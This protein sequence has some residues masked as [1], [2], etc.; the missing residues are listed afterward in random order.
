MDRP[1][2]RTILN[3]GRDAHIHTNTEKYLTK[4]RLRRH[5]QGQDYGATNK[6]KTTAPQT[7]TRLRRHKQGQDYGATNKDKTTAPQTRTS[8]RR[9][10]LRQMPATW[11][12]SLRTN[13]NDP[14]AQ[15][16]GTSWCIGRPRLEREENAVIW[17]L[18]REDNAVISG[19]TGK[20]MP[21]SRG[22]T[23]KRMPSSRGLT[24]KNAVISGLDREENAVISGFRLRVLHHE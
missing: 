20:R 11:R 19:L 4:A 16:P 2:W 14:A 7:R 17:G 9:C 21:S 10:L 15:H 6:D 24:G 13:S 1:S 5:K 12:A 8:R 23:G 22:L 18:H 3:N